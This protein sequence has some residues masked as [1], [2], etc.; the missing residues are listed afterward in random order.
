MYWYT[1]QDT[2]VITIYNINYNVH[3]CMHRLDNVEISLLNV[4]E[5]KINYDMIELLVN[6]ICSAP[7]YQVGVYVYMYIHCIYVYMGIYVYMY[8]HC[9]Y[10][11]CIHV[12]FTC[13][14]TV[15]VR[16]YVYTYSVCI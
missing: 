3:I 7:E 12:K 1:L 5:S 9:T 16:I 14:H 15:Y 13:I 10:T 11:V 2:F 8:I 4:D 6:H